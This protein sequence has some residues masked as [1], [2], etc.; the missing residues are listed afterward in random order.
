MMYVDPFFF[1]VLTSPDTQALCMGDTSRK[2]DACARTGVDPATQVSGGS[3]LRGICSPVTNA[4]ILI[5][6]FQCWNGYR[7][8]PNVMVSAS[9]CDSSH[10]RIKLCDAWLVREINQPIAVANVCRWSSRVFTGSVGHRAKAEGCGLPHVPL[11][12]VHDGERERQKRQYLCGRAETEAFSARGSVV[13]CRL[14]FRREEFGTRNAARESELRYLPR[15]RADRLYAQ[16]A[17]K[18]RRRREAGGDVPGL[19]WHR[20]PD[21]PCRRRAFARLARQYSGHLRPLSWPKISDVVV[22]PERAAIHFIP[23]ERAR[24]SDRGRLK[25][26]CGLYR[27]PRCARDSFYHRSAFAD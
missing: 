18:G 5:A 17:R 27:L 9:A 13:L 24:T 20:A 8:E 25:E 7:N 4:R 12:C 14:P 19:P 22:R 26:R 23:G 10:C 21:A 15:R 16:P 3:K 1:M 11:R 6:K 2:L